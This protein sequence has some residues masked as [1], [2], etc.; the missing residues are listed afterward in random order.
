MVS[1]IQVR[2]E[3]IKLQYIRHNQNNFRSESYAGLQYYIEHIHNDVNNENVR[4]GRSIILPSSFTGSPRF[5]S[6]LYQNA[7]AVVRVMGKPDLLITFTCNP[8]WPEIVE[9]RKPYHRVQ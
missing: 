1:K 6:N 5:M 2:I 3:Q 4:A 7:M 8:E 9:N